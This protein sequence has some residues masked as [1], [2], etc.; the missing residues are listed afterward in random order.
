[1]DC[2]VPARASGVTGLPLKFDAV[3]DALAGKA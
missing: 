2:G 3:K 1:M